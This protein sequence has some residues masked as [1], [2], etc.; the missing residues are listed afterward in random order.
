MDTQMYQSAWILVCFFFLAYRLDR[1]TERV[2]AQQ[3]EIDALKAE[4]SQCL[5]P[6]PPGTKFLPGCSY[7]DMTGLTIKPGGKQ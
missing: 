3:E 7:F 6:L 2:G 5:R 1:L 4:V